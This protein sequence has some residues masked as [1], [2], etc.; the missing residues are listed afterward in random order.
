MSYLLLYCYC[1]QPNFECI[2]FVFVWFCCSFC[3][4]IWWTSHSLY[5]TNHC[6][7]GLKIC[8][9]VCL[10]VQYVS[11]P[12]IWRWHCTMIRFYHR[13]Q[14]HMIYLFFSKKRRN[15]FD[16]IISNTSHLIQENSFQKIRHFNWRNISIEFSSICFKTY[17]S[18]CIKCIF[19]LIQ[20][21]HVSRL[22]WKHLCT[23]R[24]VT[25]IG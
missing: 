2:A 3:I 10:R 9:R 14:C 11:L 8:M 17:T 22:S 18:Y 24:T 1:D 13:T 20:F 4:Y 19:L 16:Q 23:V 21:S 7:L 25:A 12:F 15:K 6:C 5:I